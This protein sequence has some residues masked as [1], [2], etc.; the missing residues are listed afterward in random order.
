VGAEG[1]HEEMLE[2]YNA[3]K[4]SASEREKKDCGKKIVKKGQ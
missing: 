1:E 4:S 2:Q 3:E